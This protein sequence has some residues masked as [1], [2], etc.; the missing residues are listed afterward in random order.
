MNNKKILHNISFSTDRKNYLKKIKKRIAN[1]RSIELFKKN[2][3]SGN[4][5]NYKNMQKETEMIIRNPF[6]KKIHKK[7]KSEIKFNVDIEQLKKLNIFPKKLKFDKKDNNNNNDIINNIEILKKDK[8]SSSDIKKTEK[9]KIY[10]PLSIGK[11]LEPNIKINNEFKKNQNIDEKKKNKNKNINLCSL[12]VNKH[13]GILKNIYK[14]KKLKKK[15][16]QIIL[17]I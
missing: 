2:F 7:E 11:I 13:K 4:K 6:L 9:L 14:K 5:L 1:K 17:I 16:M 3:F 15:T 10:P 12:D 8:I